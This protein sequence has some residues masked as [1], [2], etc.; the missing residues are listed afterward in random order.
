MKNGNEAKAMIEL[1]AQYFRGVRRITAH[2]EACVFATHL[3]PHQQQGTI[4]SLPV[5]NARI[6]PHPAPH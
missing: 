3:P 4:Q 5:H 6:R 2:L 1:R